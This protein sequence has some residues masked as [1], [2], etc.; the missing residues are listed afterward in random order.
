MIAPP[1]RSW[2][3]APRP[4]AEPPTYADACVVAAAIV[5][6]VIAVALVRAGIIT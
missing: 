2:D 4:D 1:P 5:L 6:A 3:L